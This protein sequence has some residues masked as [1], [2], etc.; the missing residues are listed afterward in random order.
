M[1]L[2]TGSNGQLGQ[3]L[4]AILGDEGIYVDRDALDICDLAQVEGFLEKHQPKFLLNCAAYTA[5]D[6]AEGDEEQARLVNTVGPENL[7]KACARFDISLIHVSTDYV[8]DGT[9]YRP[10]NEDEPTNP[11][12][13]YGVTKLAGEQAVLR[14]AKTVAIVRT[15]WLY[16]TTGNN[17]VRTMQRLG[18]ERGALNVVADQIGSPTYAPDLAQALLAVAQKLTPG[19]KEVFHFTNEGVASWYDFAVAIMALSQIDCTVTPIPSSAYPT[20]AKRPFYSVLNKAKI[21][22]FSG[23]TIRHWREAL[24]DCLSNEVMCK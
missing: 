24:V 4:H 21:K 10:Y 23:I 17:F 15:A 16:S 6:R 7:A 5:V 22:E 9:N 19:T 13:V 11:Q 1:Y 2:I 20:P 18:R 12:S 8:F 14:E 3:A